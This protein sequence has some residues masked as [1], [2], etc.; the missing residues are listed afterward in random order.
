M[1]KTLLQ[2]VIVPAF[3]QCLTSFDKHCRVKAWGP[4]CLQGIMTGIIT[5]R[6]LSTE[7]ME[8]SAT[9]QHL[10]DTMHPLYLI[11]QHLMSC[12]AYT[13]TLT[14]TYMSMIKGGY[15]ADVTCRCTLNIRMNVVDVPGMSLVS[16]G[17]GEMITILYCH[18]IVPCNETRPHLI[19]YSRASVLLP[20]LS[21][22]QSFRILRSLSGYSAVF[23]DTPQS[24]GSA[25]DGSIHLL[26]AH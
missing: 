13:Y 23:Q 19:S 7:C 17:T 20:K 24:S 4:G 11:I 14:H 8:S 15:V 26:I 18:S 3:G 12:W 6:G 9:L 10:L 16:M 2:V 22:Q 1:F 21:S 25:R 5:Y